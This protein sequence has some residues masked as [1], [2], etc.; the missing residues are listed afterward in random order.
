M[1]SHRMSSLKFEFTDQMEKNTSKSPPFDVD[2]KGKQRKP[3]KRT[4]E[5]YMVHK[6]MIG[7]I[8]HHTFTVEY[9]E[10]HKNVARLKEICRKGSPSLHE[11]EEITKFTNIMYIMYQGQI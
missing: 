10:C 7:I 1:S 3:I 4:T 5:K 11:L 9:H 6:D 2:S 8:M